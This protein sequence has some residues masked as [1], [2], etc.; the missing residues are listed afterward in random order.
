[1]IQKIL[2]ISSNFYTKSEE[3]LI[4]PPEIFTVWHQS[5]NFK[6]IQR[7]NGGKIPPV[8]NFTTES[9]KHG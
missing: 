2:D 5:K 6:A 1:M 8:L 4:E 9:T 7:L 3:K